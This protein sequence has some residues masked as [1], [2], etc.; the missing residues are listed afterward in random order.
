MLVFVCASNLTVPKVLS[1]IADNPN[2]DYRVLTPIEQIK[3]FFDIYLSPEKI[4][5]FNLPTYSLADVSTVSKIISKYSEVKRNIDGCKST[6]VG[7]ISFSNIKLYFELYYFAEFELWL[8]KQLSLQSKEV[9]CMNSITVNPERI[10]SMPAKIYSFLN[11]YF[12][13][14]RIVPIVSSGLMT[15]LISDKYLTEIGAKTIN[16]A[17][18]DK[19]PELIF[20]KSPELRNKKIIYLAGGVVKSKSASE[21]VYIEITKQLS[22]RLEKVFS[23]DDIVV[24]SHPIYV[25][26]FA[27]ENDYS[28]MN[29]IIPLNV[30]LN[31]NVKLV[32]GFS[33]AALYEATKQKGVT[34]I[35]TVELFKGKIKDEVYKENKNY[36]LKNM[37]TSAPILFPE[38]FEAFSNILHSINI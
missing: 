21:E 16:V 18:S 14:V 27:N 3:K 32:I 29:P 13:G 23:K 30:I 12:Y 7:K 36:L 34:V 6:I 38:N 22:E 10:Q 26:Y 2:E 4:I 35:S 5:C 37:S 24:K 11:K 17:V 19:A 25:E 33:S 28:K 15:G 1:I 20:S 31:E 8:V 9:N